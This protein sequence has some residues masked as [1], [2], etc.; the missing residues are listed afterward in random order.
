MNIDTTILNILHIKLA[1]EK[2]TYRYCAL[3]FHVSIVMSIEVVIL[4]VVTP[5]SLVDGL[6]H[7]GGTFCLYL[8]GKSVEFLTSTVNIAWCHTPLNTIDWYSYYSYYPQN[9]LF[10]ILC[11]DISQLFKCLIVLSYGCCT[12]SKNSGTLNRCHCVISVTL[13]RNSST[14]V[15]IVAWNREWHKFRG[16]CAAWVNSF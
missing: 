6:W 7:F 15:T 11:G 10:S 9:N 14:L 16:F 13:L 8:Q 5:C 3:S 1:L 4:W 2:F 12:D